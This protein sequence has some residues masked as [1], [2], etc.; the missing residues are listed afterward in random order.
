MPCNSFTKTASGMLNPG[1]HSRSQLRDPKGLQHNGTSAFRRTQ[2]SGTLCRYSS[3]VPIRSSCQYPTLT[4]GI[5]LLLQQ[6]HELIFYLKHLLPIQKS[7]GGNA[8]EFQSYMWWQDST[9]RTRVTEPLMKCWC[10][11]SSQMYLRYKSI[12]YLEVGPS[13]RTK[14]MRIFKIQNT[15]IL[16]IA[17]TEC[18]T[19]TA[20][21]LHP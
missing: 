2:I 5:R 12:L 19:Y 21:C 17:N 13:W 11:H 10:V 20:V 6:L 18:S 7:E 15:L 1:E 3:S 16:Y 8:P 4:H 9:I 14:C